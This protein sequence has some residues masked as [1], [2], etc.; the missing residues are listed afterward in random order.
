MEVGIELIVEEIILKV[1][2]EV[3]V[4]VEVEFVKVVVALEVFITELL[5]WNVQNEELWISGEIGLQ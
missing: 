5:T 3:R 4:K 1:L 2:E